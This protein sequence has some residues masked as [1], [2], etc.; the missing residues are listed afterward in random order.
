MSLAARLSRMRL[1]ILGVLALALSAA[2]ANADI[3][4]VGDKLAELDIAV[5]GSGKSFKL[6]S[7]KDKWVVITIGASWCKPCKE[8]L[9]TW[10]KMAGLLGDK[11][12]FVAINA[13]N[14]IADGKKFNE[15]LKLKNMKLVYLPADKSATVE[16]YGSDTMPTTFVADGKGVVRFVKNGFSERDKDGEYKKFRAKLSDLGIK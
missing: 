13:D 6:K 1:A 10:D 14:K 11:V 3:L 2:P 9:P 15:K 12:V 16:R 8:E 7:L 4:K 5:D